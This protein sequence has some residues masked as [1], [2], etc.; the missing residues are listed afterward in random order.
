MIG[1][2]LRAVNEVDKI[3]KTI[4]DVIRIS[5]KE[6]GTLILDEKTD[7]MCKSLSTPSIKI[8]TNEF[9][10]YIPHDEDDYI[11]I[12]P[13]QTERFPWDTLCNTDNFIKMV[14]SKL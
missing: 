6:T 5:A 8:V 1:T 14:V 12:E 9:N 3:E 11:R 7:I 4:I 2:L 10:I 13:R